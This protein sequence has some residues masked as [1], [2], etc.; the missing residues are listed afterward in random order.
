MR[1]GVITFPGTH[2]DRDCVEAI[3]AVWAW[4]TVV[5]DGRAGV[6][7]DLDVVILPGGFSY[8]D[9]LRPGAIAALSPILDTVKQHAQR[10]GK[11][12]GIC[13]GFQILTEAGLLDGALAH[14]TNGTFVHKTTWVRDA[15]DNLYQL[16]VAHGAG[17]FVATPPTLA[18]LEHNG[19]VVLRYCTPDGRLENSANPNG[20]C[21]HIAGICNRERTIFGIM[22]HPERAIFPELGNTD[23][24][25]FFRW[26]ERFW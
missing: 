8:G 9:Y 26:L 5:V 15:A 20:S 13:N 4:P 10:G 7:P 17:R 6:L 23:G 24:K 22:P 2:G 14:N 12:L 25:S 16:P 19:Q 3:D 18:Q 1:V 11:V 21:D